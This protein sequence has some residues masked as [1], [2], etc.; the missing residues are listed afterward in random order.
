MAFNAVF[1]SISV[2]S[3]QSVHLSIFSWNS[4]IHGT[5]HNILI[6]LDRMIVWHV[7]PFSTVFQLYHCSQCTYPYFP[8][9]LLSMVPHTIFLPSHRLLS[10]INI[11]K[12]IHSGERGINPVEMTIIKPRKE[13]WQ[14]Y[15]NGFRFFYSAL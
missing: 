7:T 2:I 9:I 11:V 14:Y 1:D 8:G 10:H 15:F 5:P 3:L 13:Y 4:F 6:S 12:T